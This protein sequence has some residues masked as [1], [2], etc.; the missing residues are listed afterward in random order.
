MQGS[1]GL[2]R[3]D[4]AFLVAATIA[5]I[6]AAIAHFSAGAAVSFVAA[7]IALGLLAAVVGEATEHLGGRLA[8][9]ATGVIHSALGNLPELLVCGFSL[10]AGLYD[11]VKGALV[12][13][14]VA[15]SVLVL[16]LAFFLG[17]LKHG[18]MKFQSEGPRLLALL[19]VLAAAAIS[20]PTLAELTRSPAASHQTSLALIVAVVLFVVYVGSM[21][22]VMTGDKD[23][24]VE[25]CE[26]TAEH[27]W[28]MSMIIGVLL[29]AGFASGYVS[30]WF[31][32]ALRPATQALHI[33]EAFTG[34]VIVAL[35]GNAVENIVGVQLALKKKPDYA[36]SVILN[37]TLQIALMLLPLVV[38][39]SFAIGPTP[40]S[41]V[42]SPMLLFSLFLSAIIPLFVILDGEMIWLEGVAL[43]GL[44]VLI[45]ASF[46]WG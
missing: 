36:L 39:G 17:G 15:N 20:I 3:K 27:G 43:I 12:G 24:V 33:S 32:D 46:W 42:M 13:S 14:I 29:V 26:A 31:V 19:V 1:S 10:K 2:T 37:S 34:L 6:I 30:D 28:K 41:L 16:G 23:F 7:G 21:R 22:F 35:A 18:K 11:V 9:G 40:L 45:A 5:T 38:F 4:K 8:P 44:Y 25:D